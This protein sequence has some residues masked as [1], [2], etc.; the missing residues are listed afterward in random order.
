MLTNDNPFYFTLVIVYEDD[1]VFI[2]VS[3]LTFQW[4]LLLEPQ[5]YSTSQ[6]S[7]HRNSCLF[8]LSKTFKEAV[9]KRRNAQYSMVIMALNLCSMSRNV[10][11]RSLN[12]PYNGTQE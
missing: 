12:K 11:G 9:T 1:I 7:F 4:Q 5:S 6:G 2:L 10:F 3:N 8:N